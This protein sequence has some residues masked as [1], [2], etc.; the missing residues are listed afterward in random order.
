MAYSYKSSISF[1]LVYIPVTLHACIK[2]NDISFNLIDKNTM[3]RIRYKKTC[4]DCD[5]R[6]V[7]N[8]DIVKGYQYQD[9]SYV[10]LEDQDFEK[11]KS[12]KDK[13]IA[14]KQFVDIKSIDP[15]YFNKTYYVVPTGAEQAYSLLMGAMES[16]G[17]AGIAKAVLG[18]K[19]T[20]IL[21]RVKDG[22]M[23]LNTLY[24]DDEVQESPAKSIKPVTSGKELELAQNLIENM[25]DDFDISSY[26]DEYREKLMSLIDSKISGKTLELPK[27][28]EQRHVGSLMDALIKSIEFSKQSNDEDKKETKTRASTKQPVRKSVS[29]KKSTASKTSK[30]KTTRKTAVGS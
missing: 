10:V 3:S 27:E 5:G 23:L 24:F 15:V 18:T 25:I 4:V 6:E 16:K 29:S 1:G 11:I 30:T 26:K 22:K 2:N 12:K 20:L 14:I 9:D 17:M 19:D 28:T 8:E 13:T 7:K 21:L